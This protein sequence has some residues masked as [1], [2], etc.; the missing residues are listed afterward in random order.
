M[1]KTDPKPHRK[2]EYYN[3]TIQLDQEYTFE[4][5]KATNG[6]TKYEVVNITPEVIGD[7]HNVITKTIIN[8]CTREGL[9]QIENK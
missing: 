7:I 2:V 9:G 3:G 4:V 8:H 1:I 6:E 5:S